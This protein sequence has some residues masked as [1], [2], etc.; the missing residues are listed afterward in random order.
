MVEV[1]MESKWVDLAIQIVATTIGIAAGALVGGTFNPIINS[2]TG[3]AKCA[4]KAG[5]FGIETVVVY[6]VASTMNGNI[7]EC[8]EAYNDMARK[9]NAGE[10]IINNEENVNG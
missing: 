1:N 10:K 4:C 6:K 9:V 8:V 7:C 5:K 2:K 3:I